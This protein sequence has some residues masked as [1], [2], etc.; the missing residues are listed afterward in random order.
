MLMQEQEKKH[1]PISDQLLQNYVKIMLY[2]IGNQ[3]RNTGMTV[4]AEEK[5]REEFRAIVYSLSSSE[6]VALA[7]RIVA[8][9]RE[10]LQEHPQRGYLTLGILQNSIGLRLSERYLQKHPEI[11]A[12]LTEGEVIAYT[13][14]EAET[15]KQLILAL[16]DEVHKGQHYNIV[17]LID[18][19]TGDRINV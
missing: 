2:V 15:L 12:R 10:C 6:L 18:D 14:E 9:V 8:V 5:L 16:K 7:K 1:E 11:R 13:P 17:S 3:E 19:V 4:E